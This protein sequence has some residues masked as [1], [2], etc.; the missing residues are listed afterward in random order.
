MNRADIFVQVMTETTG[1]PKHVV[2]DYFN[3]FRKAVPGGEWD[4][5]LS[6]ERAE[7]LIQ[8]LRSERDG[9]FSMLVKGLIEM[10]RLKGHA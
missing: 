9:I 4:Q 10:N 6:P 5:E 7:N 1:R 3:Q 2:I 8:G